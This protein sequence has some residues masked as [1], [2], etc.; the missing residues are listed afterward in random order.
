MTAG[1]VGDDALPVTGSGISCTW[2]RGCCAN[3][4]SIDL[5]ISAG[6]VPD[7]HLRKQIAQLHNT[8]PCLSTR[9]KLRKHML[10]LTKSRSNG[11][12]ST[13]LTMHAVS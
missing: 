1:R 6:L 11:K 2:P 10:Q 8:T 3:A 12:Q 13:L 5:L 7:K 9:C 4:Q